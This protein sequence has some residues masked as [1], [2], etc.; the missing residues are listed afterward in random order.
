MRIAFLGLGQMGANLA[1]LLLER[2]YDLTIWNRTPSA[3]ER[4][5]QAGA[6][7]AQ[8]PALAVVDA[9]LVF[10]MVHDDEALES[11]LLE[12]GALAAIP[13]GATHV[14]LSTISPA[15][16]DRL[17]AEHSAHQQNFVACPVFGR[18]AIAA[19][20]K[21]WLAIAGAEPVVTSILPILDTFSRGY[22]IVGDKPSAASAVKVGGNFLITAMIA[23]L[24]EGMVFAE[25]HGI[26][27]ALYLE[28]V[29]AALFQ[30]QFYANYGKVMLNPPEQAAATVELGA[31]DTR[32]FREAASEMS[33]GTP[34]ADIFQQHLD[35]AAAA[36]LG[37]ADWAAGYYQ[38][39][40][41]QS[42]GVAAK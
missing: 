35:E 24:S 25:A 33:T 23:S 11:I 27:P 22:T 18:P 32:L 4:L 29:N 34:L 1:R 2:G 6:T 28:L 17:A 40:Q 19:E 26:D 9:E 38:F 5:A 15:L 10:T 21:L 14:S 20:G 42:K 39:I 31:K 41:Q 36:G 7:V 13:S 16:S 30:S 12:Q 8:T 37:R 3:A